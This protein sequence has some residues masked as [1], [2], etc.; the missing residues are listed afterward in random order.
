MPDAS[1]ADTAHDAA[2][3]GGSRGSAER[4]AEGPLIE[5]DRRLAELATTGDETFGRLGGGE[6]ALGLA[7]M[8]VLPLVLVWA[9]A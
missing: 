6:L 2:R 1:D 5:L 4:G 3:R 7:L 8:V 9:F